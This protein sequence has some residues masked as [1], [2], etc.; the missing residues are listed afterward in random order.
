MNKLAIV[1]IGRW[2]KVL[3]GEFN[4]LGNI[5]YAVN[6]GNQEEIKWIKKNFP[7]ILHTSDV[8]SLLHRKGIDSIII[9]TPIK[10][11]FKIA[12]KCLDL[13]KNVFIEKPPCLSSKEGFELLKIA[14]LKKKTLFVD[15]TYC[16]EPAFAKL[17]KIT[18]VQKP[19]DTRFTWLKWGTFNSDIVWNLAYHDIYLSLKLYGKPRRSRLI[20]KSA[21]RVEIELIYK[22][23]KVLILID[24]SYKGL[25]SK[26][27]LIKL[28]HKRYLLQNSNLYDVKND[29][30][31]LVFK[32]KI[33]PLSIAC[34][35]FV[36]EINKKRKDYKNFEL[37]IE[38]VNVIEKMTL[39]R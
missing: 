28:D 24:R 27:V 26:S 19:Q 8:N 25:P 37:S 38:A 34:K 5:V 36:S 15:N 29:Q 2:G 30:K 9:A 33:T 6:N 3:V 18:A 35:K 32:S 11:H 20:S 13:N 12:K 22:N 16:F 17:K 39:K 4:K 10:T 23:H 7:S 14:R 1:G 31:K 21:N